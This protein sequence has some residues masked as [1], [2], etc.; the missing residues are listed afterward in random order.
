MVCWVTRRVWLYLEN[1]VCVLFIFYFSEIKINFAFHETQSN[2]LV[3][4]ARWEKN[5]EALQHEISHRFY[6]KHVFLT[7]TSS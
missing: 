2:F 4:H 6:Y 3:F 1:H 7:G 5:Q